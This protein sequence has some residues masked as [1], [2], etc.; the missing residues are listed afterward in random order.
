MSSTSCKLIVIQTSIFVQ[1]ECQHLRKH[2]ESG[3]WTTMQHIRVIFPRTDI[4]SSFFII[5][6]PSNA[7][8]L[9]LIFP[10][11]QLNG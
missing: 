5:T 6:N 3:Q 10:K 8:V 2:L 7:S 11:L 4:K 9:Q 1:N